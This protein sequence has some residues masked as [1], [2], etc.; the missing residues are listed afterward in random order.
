MGPKGRDL[1]RNR[2]FFERDPLTG[3]F[4]CTMEVPPS[5][6]TD[7]DLTNAVRSLVDE[8][9]E[10]L[11]IGLARDVKNHRLPA[12]NFST[13]M[14]QSLRHGL[15]CYGSDLLSGVE[16]FR[17]LYRIGSSVTHEIRRTISGQIGIDKEGWREDWALVEIDKPWN[18]LNQQRWDTLLLQLMA[19]SLGAMKDFSPL[20]TA[21][22][23]PKGD[24]LT[25]FKDGRVPFAKGGD[26]GAAVTTLSHDRQSLVFGGTVASMFVVDAKTSEN[27][28][29]VIPQSAIFRQIHDKTGL[30]LQLH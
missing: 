8:D 3:R 28:V 7:N 19:T 4:I 10:E 24:G 13:E 5:T 18:T 16:F 23:D 27:L 12:R 2:Y 30:N 25:W 17:A 15:I 21:C 26:S 6:Q 14:M 1:G 11:F 29:F 9:S 20:L 22:E